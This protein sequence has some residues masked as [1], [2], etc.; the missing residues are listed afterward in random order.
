MFYSL[1]FDKHAN[2][3]LINIGKCVFHHLFSYR[4]FLAITSVQTYTL[5]LVIVL[6][7]FTLIYIFILQLNYCIMIVAFAEP[8]LINSSYLFELRYSLSLYIYIER[9]R[10]I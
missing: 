10:K 5:Y 2:F 8:I 6:T 4:L 9:E 3:F 1:L 7:F